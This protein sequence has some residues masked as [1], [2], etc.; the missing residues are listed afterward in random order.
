MIGKMFVSLAIFAIG[1]GCAL[2]DAR[3]PANATL[4]TGD[5]PLVQAH[6]GSRGEYDDNAAGGFKWCL[7]KGV[8]GFEADIRFTKD[9][10]L[11]VM[12]DETVNRTTGAIGVTESFT[13]QEIRN[14]RL[15]MSS[16]PVPTAQELFNVLK[17]QDDIFIEIEMK[18]YPSQFYTDEVLEDY[19][20]KL[21]AAAKEALERGTYAFTCFNIKTLETMR[22]VAPE[23]PLGYI[24]GKALSEEH[25]ATAKRLNCCNVSPSGTLTTKE[26]ID[27]AHEEGLCVCLW[28]VQSKAAWDIMK[29]KG[30]DRITS[31]YPVLLTQAINSKKK[32][33]V[34]IDLDAALGKDRANTPKENLDTLKK[35]E[36]KYKCI[37]FGDNY[38]KTL[39]WAKENG[40]EK[41]DIV[42]VGDDFADNASAKEV[43]SEGMERILITN[44][45]KFPQAVKVLLD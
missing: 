43:R 15:K 13:L 23:A 1:S 12:H 20:R 29:E 45:K 27:R 38:T 8:K 14:M 17:D 35:L 33:V 34:S 19:C 9:H 26:M 11:V 37:T 30:A 41:E 39:A 3:Y 4:K 21:N 18:A 2:T 24:V 7:E 5:G 36:Q 44:Y 28:M 32:K 42:F 6:R 16:E 31:D 10:Q 25:I 22:R 40:Y